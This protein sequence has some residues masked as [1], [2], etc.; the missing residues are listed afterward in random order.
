MTRILFVLAFLAVGVA[1][2]GM[3]GDQLGATFHA[4]AVAIRR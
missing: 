3:F 2:L 4:A 1:L